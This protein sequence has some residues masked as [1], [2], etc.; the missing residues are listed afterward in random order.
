MEIDKIIEINENIKIRIIIKK[1]Y[2][3]YFSSYEMAEFKDKELERTVSFNQWDDYGFN[4]FCLNCDMN[5]INKVDFKID[6]NNLFYTPLKKFLGNEELIIID[7]DDT[8][9]INKKT[10]QFLQAK[11][12]II[13]SFDNQLGKNEM[14]KFNIFVKNILTDYRSKIDD[15]N[16]DTKDRLYKL[17]EDL[18]EVFCPETLKDYPLKSD[19][20]IMRRTHTKKLIPNNKK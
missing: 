7:D 5:I 6:K 20:I 2:C 9:E 10:L 1:S 12:V 15:G 3:G 19:E 4:A 8:R 11:D 17:F 18:R 13:I 14:E 16:F